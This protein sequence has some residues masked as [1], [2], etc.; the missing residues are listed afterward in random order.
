MT[1]PAKIYKIV[2]SHCDKL[3][4][5]SCRQIKGLSGRMFN[6]RSDCNKGKTSKLYSHMREQGFDK[7]TIHLI[8]NVE[9]ADFDEQR[10]KEQEKIE[11]L[12]T[13]N[14]GLNNRRSYCSIEARKEQN[15][16]HS[17]KQCATLALKPGYKDSYNAY[18]RTHRTKAIIQSCD[19]CD[20]ETNRPDSLVR[21]R[22]SKQHKK[23][24]KAE[25]LRVFGRE[26][27]DEEI[28]DYS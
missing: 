3:Y 9:V 13:I 16:R 4:V 25:F 24:Y 15:L 7:F 18:R 10:M 28:T 17:R 19:C 8:E 2:C 27:K 11:L 23:A 22:Q 1:Y 5:G 6:H 26:I 20:Y 14:N 21:H 12:D